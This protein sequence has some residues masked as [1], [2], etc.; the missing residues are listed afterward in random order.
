MENVILKELENEKNKKTFGIFE[1]ALGTLLFIIFNFAFI[2]LFR[3]IPAGIRANKAVYYIA[4]FFIEFLF[5]VTAYTVAKSR[6][7][8]I[9]NETGMTKKISGK[10][11]F[12]SIL[13]ALVCLFFLSD[14][15]SVFLDFLSLCGYKAQ[16]SDISINTFWQ[17]LVYIIISCITPAIC[18][19]ILFRG[20]IASGLKGLGKTA[21]VVLSALIFMLMHGNPEQTIH[22]FLIGLIVGYIFLSTGNIWIGVIIHFVNNFISVTASYAMSFYPQE[23]VAGNAEIVTNPWLALFIEFVIAVIWAVAAFFILRAIIKRI[24]KENERINNSQIETDAN[25]TILVDGKETET[26]MMVDGINQTA[27]EDIDNEQSPLSKEKKKIS[28]EDIS[29]ITVVMFVLSGIYLIFDWLS[30][31]LSGLGI[32]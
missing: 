12:L 25:A 10:L 29:M 1:A 24:K 14:L 3:L 8:V 32:L 27:K 17:Y 6:K 18:E 13:V 11:V 28:R 15:T 31:L 21:A 4:S 23:V 16:L 9:Q 26:V 5:G 22:Q 19:E 7:I 20:V 2:F 30:V